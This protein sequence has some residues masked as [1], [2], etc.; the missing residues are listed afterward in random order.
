MFKAVL[1][2]LCALF[3]FSAVA[4]AEAFKSGKDCVVGARVADS[5]NH[6]GTIVKTDG[7]M[8]FVKRD[9]GSS[10]SYTYIFWMLHPVGQ[11]AE[12]NDKLIPGKYSCYAGG[13]YV[14]IDIQITGPNTYTIDNSSGKF[15]IDPSRAIVFETGFLKSYTAK[16][17]H[18]PDIELSTDGGKFYGTTCSYQKN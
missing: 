11:S 15:H 6:T 14:F 17:S 10:D 4:S 16:L 8:C 3:A 5:T 13:R 18:G 12:T 1:V 7:T 9:D 2:T